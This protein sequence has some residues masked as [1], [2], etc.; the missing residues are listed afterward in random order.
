MAEQGMNCILE[1]KGTL[2]G[3]KTTMCGGY[4]NDGFLLSSNFIIDREGL[5]ALVKTLGSVCEDAVE[6]FVEM[7]G[8]FSTEVKLNYSDEQTLVVINSDSLKFV[9]YDGEGKLVVFNI[10]PAEMIAGKNN[11]LAQI[12]KKAVYYFGIKDFTFLYRSNNITSNNLYKSFGYLPQIP[13]VIKDSVVICGR[14]DFS[15]VSKSMFTKAMTELFGINQMGVYLGAGSS[16]VSCAL[17]VPDM[18]NSILKCRNIILYAQFGSK[19]VRFS[20]EGSIAL[21]CFS[22]MEFYVKCELSMTSVSISACS[23]PTNTYTIPKTPLTICNSGLQIGFDEKGLNFAIMTQ[24]NIRSLMWYG[25]LRMSYQGTTVMLDMLSMAMSEVSLAALAENLIGLPRDKVSALDIIAVRTFNLNTSQAD[26]K[27]DFKNKTDNQII[28]LINTALKGMK[29]EFLLS[30]DSASITRM[31][32]NKACDV[33]NELTMFHYWINENGELSFPPQAYYSSSHICIG[34]YNFEKGIFFCGKMD[35]FGFGI[36]VM[37]SALYG[38]GFMGFAQIDEINTKFLKISGSRSSRQM[39][40][41]VLGNSTNSTLSLLVNDFST[42]KVIKNPAIV[43]VSVS[44]NSCEFYIDAHYELCSFFSFDTLMYYI[45]KHIH[46]ATTISYFNMISASIYL[47]VAYA[48][49]SSANFEFSIS[50][51]CMGF[52]RKVVNLTKAID[53]AVAAYNRKIND[54]KR[55]ISDASNKV[56]TLQNDINSYHNKIEDCKRTIRNTSRWKR[57][58]VAIREGI[59]I[60]AFETAILTLKAA[61]TVAE[62]ALEIA[63]KVLELSGKLGTNL[64]NAVNSVI[65]GA[66]DAFYINSTMLHI[67]VNGN[68]RMV[69]G[70]IDMKVLGKDINVS[71][72]CNLDTL[73]KKP[74]EFLENCILDQIKSIIDSLKKGEYEYVAIDEPLTYRYIEEPEELLTISELANLGATRMDSY[75]DMLKELSEVYIDEMKDTSPDFE[76]CDTQIKETATQLSYIMESAAANTCLDGMDELSARLQ[77]GLENNE[78][79]DEDAK[80]VKACIETYMEELRPAN[81]IITEAAAQ[82]Q[83]QTEQMDTEYKY[84]RLRRVREDNEDSTGVDTLESKDYDKLY[85]EMESVITKYFPPGSG[86]GLFNFTDEP[87]FYEMLNEARDEAGCAVIPTEVEKENNTLSLDGYR[88][89]K[90]SVYIPRLD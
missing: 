64:L 53:D 76:D 3:I 61:M 48:K 52:H 90:K 29:K 84:T 62:G 33:L 19:G 21:S 7:L 82:V 73:A 11:S 75:Q 28:E 54:A 49:F 77:E 51:D 65:R 70:A 47:D 81:S 86:K 32:N 72:S 39:K 34:K 44:R 13:Y 59:K 41:P 66:L 55:Q 1:V 89:L 16:N 17:V 67:L 57:W 68:T 45:N 60:A 14:F 56:R 27:I 2:C 9:G 83:M 80:E 8:D 31:P 63:N 50:L 78:F 42:D 20:M 30:P 25:A 40:N 79:S 87:M 24:I 74:I 10:A 18:E 23:M 58:W 71:C 85:N 12:V 22:G 37:F 35:L 69:E 4:A 88:M 15:S 36:K 5:C 43:Y 38:N 46:I 26:T 6:P